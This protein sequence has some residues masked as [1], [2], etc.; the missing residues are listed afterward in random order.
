[1]AAKLILA[2]DLGASLTKAIYR[3]SVDGSVPINRVQTFCSAVARITP[4]RFLSKQYAD[5]NTALV[6]FENTFWM[7]GVAAQQTVTI[8]NARTLKSRDAIAKILAVVGQVAFQHDVPLSDVQIELGV[9]LPLD[10]MKG[11]EKLE[12][13]ISNA[14]YAFGFNGIDSGCAEVNALTIAPEGYGYA[15]LAQQDAAIV[16]M[17]GHRD[18]ASLF[19]NKKS[20]SIAESRPLPG[21]GMIKL[22]NLMNYP[23]KD[24]LG[25]AEAIFNV[26]DVF[27]R[28]K[29]LLR[30]IPPEDVRR[31]LVQ[32]EEARSLAWDLLWDEL[33]ASHINKAEQVFA[34]GGNAFY[35]KPELKKAVGSKLSVAVELLGEM[36]ERFPELHDGKKVQLVYRCGD[37]YAFWKTLIGEEAIPKPATTKQQLVVAPVSV[38]KAIVTKEK[39]AKEVTSV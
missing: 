36:R 3:L 9:L 2:V 33:L 8:T 20:V 22:L 24:E 15:Q 29:P 27:T 32:I 7:V 37:C 38:V 10:E 39:K 6:A 35:W 18:A 17:F 28:E 31:V 19:I 4:S 16:L 14:L 30:I 34:A 5:D 21:W 13:Q 26:G 12:I 25:A 11:Y 23:F 1:M